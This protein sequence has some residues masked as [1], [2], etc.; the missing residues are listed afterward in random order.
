MSRAIIKKNDVDSLSKDFDSLIPKKE[1]TVISA[2]FNDM[3]IV[4]LTKCKRERIL[5]CENKN[6]YAQIIFRAMAEVYRDVQVNSNTHQKSILDSFSDG[7]I[8]CIPW[9]NRH[10][11]SDLNKYKVIYRPH[12]LDLT[13]KGNTKLISKILFIL[14]FFQSNNTHFY[15]ALN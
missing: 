4:I 10:E 6:E 7:L 15:W 9:L 3:R 2:P 8:A 5:I 1:N 14:L 13:K 11:I 12:P